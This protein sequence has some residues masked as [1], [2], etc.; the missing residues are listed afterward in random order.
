MLCEEATL[1]C[2]KNLR[3]PDGFPIELQEELDVFVKEKSATRTEF[4]EAM[5]SGI[6]VNAVF[7]VRQED[8]YQTKH[9]TENG[10]AAYAT[11]IRYDG[12]VYD[13]VR[14]Y[15]NDKSMIELIC[16]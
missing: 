12:T 11:K 16:A 4:Y 9:T 10:K 6:T 3:D 14:T 7:E 13:I 1:I 5:R 2:S 15:R 8:F